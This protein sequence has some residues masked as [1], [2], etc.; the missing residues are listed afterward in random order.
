MLGAGLP[1]RWFS[2]QGASVRITGGP[3]KMVVLPSLSAGNSRQMSRLSPNLHNR[4]A[5]PS[6]VDTQARFRADTARLRLAVM[7]CRSLSRKL[8]AGFRHNMWLQDGEAGR[9]C[10]PLSRLLIETFVDL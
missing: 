3:G 4:F 7:P 1:S 6:A 10:A 5:C 2:H 8:E 9:V